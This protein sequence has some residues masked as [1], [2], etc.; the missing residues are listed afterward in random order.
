MQPHLSSNSNE[1]PIPEGEVLVSKTDLKG[2]INYCNQTLIE[3]SGYCRDEL[4]L[5]PHKLLRHEDVPQQVFADLWK[6]IQANKPWRGVIKNRR[7]HGDYYWVEANITPLLDN[8]NTTGYVSFSYQASPEQ[9]RD[10]SSANESMRAGTSR[11]RINNGK[12]IRVENPLLRWL[13]ASSLKFRLMAFMSILVSALIVTGIFN[14]Y[15]AS[16]IH[17]LS[18]HSLEITRLEAYALD[19]AR[20]AELDFKEQVHLWQNHL[21]ETR[22]AALFEHNLRNYEQQGQDFKNRLNLLKNFMQQIDLPIDSIN[23]VLD[24]H[25]LLT[26][27]LQHALDSSSFPKR[28]TPPSISRDFKNADLPTLA[29]L[30]IVVSTIQH[31]QQER[32][33]ELNDNL[34]KSHRKENL[35]AFVMLLATTLAGLFL[36]MPLIISI[37][38]PVNSTTSRLKKVVKLQ[39]HFLQIIFKLEQYRDRLDEEQRLAH[40]IMGRI[41][42]MNS[43]LARDIQL[44]T[45]PAE[46]L[47]G[48]VL[49]ASN[50][51][52]DVVHILLADAIGHGLAAAINVL[53]LCRTFYT[54][55]GR[56]FGIDMIA[57]ELNTLVKQL[58]PPDRFVSATLISINRQTR[59]IAV[60]NG[61]I[62]ALKLFSRDGQLLHSWN[63]HNL[64]LGILPDECFKAQPEIIR[65]E[66]D[67]QLCLFSDG[68]IEATSPEGRQFGIESIIELFGN[69]L[70]EARLGALISRLE[71]HLA[72][73]PAHDDISLAIV[74][75]SSTS[76]QTRPIAGENTTVTEKKRGNWRMSICLE[77]QELKHLD[78]I[79]FLTQIISR[80]HPSEKHNA[81]LFMILSELFN[82]AFNQGLLGLSPSLG[83]GSD[84]FTSHLEL[85]EKRLN[86]LIGGEIEIAIESMPTEDHG[87]IKIYVR[88]SKGRFNT[89]LIQDIATISDNWK[90][91][92]ITKALASKLDYADCGNGIT[93]YY[94][95]N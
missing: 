35:R 47:S 84:A 46:H 92:E 90:D 6:T 7:K 43:Q 73:N 65:F 39:Q 75:I 56:G 29:L 76:A 50:T 16:K 45:K 36:S 8:G 62:P 60:W 54:L 22:D 19:T 59:K 91:I 58:M 57:A 33:Q 93:A 88:N 31:S 14:R 72:G 67:C 78:I 69:T 4:I 41:T 82:C 38:K 68:L 94:R 37:M 28:N 66:Q 11:L 74:D 61:G 44:Y 42:E 26:N 83:L 51:P 49:I 52:A 40:F 63:S 18:I 15:E 27:R 48:D 23:R 32:L 9:I 12:I 20:I 77:A 87:I 53:P 17:A 13:N 24:A 85:R 95:C 81:A 71:R 30:E 89:D 79:P 80:V 86:A 3:V 55:T 10:F 21:F 2:I 5:Q 1:Y 25:S 34:E 64:P 70:P